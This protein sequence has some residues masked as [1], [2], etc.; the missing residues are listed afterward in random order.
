M[1]FYKFKIFY[2]FIF[3][4]IFIELFYWLIIIHSYF[5]FFYFF[6]LQSHFNFVIG[7]YY[8][9]VQMEM[10]TAQ[11][12]QERGERIRLL[13]EKEDSELEQFDEESTR[14]GFRLVTYFLFV[15]NSLIISNFTII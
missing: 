4:Y 7:F 1:C 9:A 13:R 5:L 6:I 3:F 15:L 8:R 12:L 14:L 2:I 10:E 11:F